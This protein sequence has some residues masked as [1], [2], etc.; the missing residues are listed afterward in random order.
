MT[1]SRLPGIFGQRG[2]VVMSGFQPANPDFAARV[3]DSFSRQ[4]F[5]AFIGAELAVVEP[6]VCEIHLPYRKE[7][8]QQHGYV[9]GGALATLADN[10]AGYAAF[11]LMP[12]DASVL[13]VEYKL[14]IVRPGLGDRMTARAKVIK[15]GRT[16]TVV[17]SN[18]Y[19]VENDKEVMCV[20]SIQTI[21]ALHG[22]E[23]S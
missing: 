19:G 6:G 22:R 21:M 3:R 13:T 23:D 11:S 5:M 4:P 1:E 12:A 15:A 20:T 8:T 10:A 2:A 7:L 18:V 9:H 17:E 14:N 16:I